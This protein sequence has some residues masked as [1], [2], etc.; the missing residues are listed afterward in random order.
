[1]FKNKNLIILATILSYLMLKIFIFDNLKKMNQIKLP[2]IMK[3]VL[4]I[5][6]N[7][8]LFLTMLT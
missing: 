2:V 8:D 6:I 4:K 1:M 7:T 3:L 5:K